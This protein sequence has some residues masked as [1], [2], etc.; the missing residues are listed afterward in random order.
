MPVLT[1]Y[2]MLFSSSC[3]DTIKEKNDSNMILI[4]ADDVEMIDFNTNKKEI[5]DE[6][7]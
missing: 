3:I 1:V 5:Y 7:F 4:L 6:K 2:F